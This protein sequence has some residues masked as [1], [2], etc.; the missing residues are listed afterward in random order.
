MIYFL[1]K[2]KAQIKDNSFVLHQ[3]KPITWKQSL[4]ETYPIPAPIEPIIYCTNV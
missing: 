2:K 3:I 4:F 1:S